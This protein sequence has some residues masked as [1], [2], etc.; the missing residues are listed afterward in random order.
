M[1]QNTFIS[2]ICLLGLLT[3]APQG[4]GQQKPKEWDLLDCINYALEN[5]IQIKK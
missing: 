1:K 2:S 3:L 5:N 4:F